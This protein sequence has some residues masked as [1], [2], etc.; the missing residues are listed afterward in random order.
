M[1]LAGSEMTPRVAEGKTEVIGSFYLAV[2]GML[3]GQ[4]DALRVARCLAGSKMP[5]GQRDVMRIFV[6]VKTFAKALLVKQRKFAGS[7]NIYKIL[8]NDNVRTAFSRL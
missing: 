3:C 5:R 6:I 7:G 4:R 2:S 8:N 1:E